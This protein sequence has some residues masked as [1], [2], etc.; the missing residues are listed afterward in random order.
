MC[1]DK[2]S[3]GN[4]ERQ[5]LRVIE[6]E[7]QTVKLVAQAP[8]R[9]VKRELNN[10]SSAKASIAPEFCVRST[11]AEQFRLVAFSACFRFSEWDR[12]TAKNPQ[13]R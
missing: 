2:Q 5:K 11:R 1:G 10:L 12:K 4:I 6:H 8:A 13:L 9:G 7:R 3:T